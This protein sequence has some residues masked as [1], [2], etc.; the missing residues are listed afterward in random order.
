MTIQQMVILALQASI[1]LTVFGFGLQAT[2]RDMQYLLRRPGLLARSLVSMFVVMPIVAV[3]LVRVFE[4]RP[5]LEVAIVML[6]ISP[7]PPLLPG[8]ESK[9][10]GHAAYG[11]GLM[12][13]VSLLAIVVVPLSLVI[14]GRYFG[15]DLQ[16]PPAAI[17]KVVFTMA[18]LPLAAGMLARQ[19]VPALAARMARPI[20]LVA[21][22]LLLVGAAALVIA[23]FPVMLR[24]IGEGTMLAIAAFVGVGLSVGH[25]LGGPQAEEA[26]VLALSTASRH[27][28]I[29]FAAAT[30]N[31]P[32]EPNLGATILL[33]LLLLAL[34]CVPYIALQR[35]LLVPRPS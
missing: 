8:K 16:M 31:F 30:M 26:S 27:P 7:V 17:A 19:F 2:W 3:I 18:L 12:A 25:W 14:L 23:A 21:T 35:R 9:A 15:R 6:A 5:S 34:L 1:L 29:A 28:A 11:V 20:K 24:L 32:D 13:I 33:Y 22:V 4:L 10:G